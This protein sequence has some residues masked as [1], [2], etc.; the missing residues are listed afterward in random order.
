MQATQPSAASS[1]PSTAW[2]RVEPPPPLLSRQG[3]TPLELLLPHDD[4]RLGTYSLHYRDLEG[5]LSSVRKHFGMSVGILGVPVPAAQDAISEMCTRERPDG[6][7]VRCGG[8]A[9]A[10]F[11]AAVSLMESA[12]S[13]LPA[14]SLWSQFGIDVSD[15][16]L[17]AC[18]RLMQQRRL[19]APEADHGANFDTCDC[20]LRGVVPWLRQ[21]VLRPWETSTATTL[22]AVCAPP[23]I[24][25]QPT[26]FRD[27]STAPDQP[28]HKRPRMSAKQERLFRLVRQLDACVDV[29]GVHDNW[30]S[31][32][33][34]PVQPPH[35]HLRASAL[36]F[37]PMTWVL[38]DWIRQRSALQGM[39]LQHLLAS[40]QGQSAKFVPHLPYPLIAAD[41][42]K[43]A[44]EF[45]R[46]I[47]SC[48][49]AIHQAQCYPPERHG[50][51]LP[52][53]ETPSE[54]D[55][56]ITPIWE[57]VGPRVPNTSIFISLPWRLLD[58]YCRELLSMSTLNVA[59]PT[60]PLDDDTAHGEMRRIAFALR[61]PDPR[62]QFSEAFP[63]STMSFA[64]HVVAMNRGGSDV[65]VVEA[66]D[67]YVT[68]D[69]SQLGRVR[70]LTTPASIADHT[71]AKSC[72]LNFKVVAVGHVGKC[73]EGL[74]MYIIPLWLVGLVTHRL[75]YT[76]KRVVTLRH[77]SV[78]EAYTPGMER[79]C[80]PDQIRHVRYLMETGEELDAHSLATETRAE[81]EPP[82]QAAT[83]IL[84]HLVGDS[85]IPG[86]AGDDEVAEEADELVD[87]YS[88]RGV[89]WV[90]GSKGGQYQVAEECDFLENEIMEVA[91]RGRPQAQP[92]PHSAAGHGG[93]SK[94]GGPVSLVS[95]L[96]QQAE[97][98]IDLAY[99]RARQGRL[100]AKAREASN[101]IGKPT[102]SPKSLGDLPIEGRLKWLLLQ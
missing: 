100:R 4:A 59:L 64:Q 47:E 15:G 35:T 57:A 44:H 92:A 86:M 31:A 28:G 76:D 96:R 5:T 97:S 99:E 17:I 23:K 75:G 8:S 22:R 43:F 30:D 9:V 81:E 32:N 53:S 36:L 14:R 95:E 58:M 26:P 40:N 51:S 24:L 41:F 79:F 29:G 45:G 42:V 38:G 6:T 94:R 98:A 91:S 82:N 16:A 74:M 70:R 18:V 78:K 84:S 34:G 71:L 1:L 67:V 73:P 25:L 48:R 77:R 7:F 3:G 88:T 61:R 54:G 12:R 93:H 20:S 90:V 13:E 39:P 2:C 10:S 52:P 49:A 21:L 87:S 80:L 72:C 66:T 89:G 102:A 85:E 37:V 62:S 11:D 50:E 27:G 55:E 65:V 19:Q 68:A 56:H 101:L 63:S 46:R 69:E 60:H 83:M 33:L